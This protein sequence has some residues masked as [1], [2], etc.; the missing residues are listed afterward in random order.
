MLANKCFVYCDEIFP[1]HDALNTELTDLD[2]LMVIKSFN[3]NG[4]KFKPSNLFVM[5]SF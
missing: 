3:F 5:N 1:G 2:N 4:I